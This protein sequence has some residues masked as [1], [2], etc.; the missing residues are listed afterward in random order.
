M[1]KGFEKSKTDKEAKSKGKEGGK[2]E[3]AFDK[4]QMMKHSKGGAM[5]GKKC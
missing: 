1:K 5:K 2:K 4:M 3:D